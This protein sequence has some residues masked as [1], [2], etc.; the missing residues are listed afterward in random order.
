MD[1]C[2]QLR[3]KQSGATPTAR[4]RLHHDVNVA[5]EQDEK[6]HETIE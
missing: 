1:T 4:L 6:S 5:S 3:D 2:D